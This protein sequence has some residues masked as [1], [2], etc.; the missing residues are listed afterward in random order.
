M[1]F[2]INPQVAYY[3]ETMVM[4]IHHSF[5][6]A[7]VRLNTIVCS[8]DIFTHQLMGSCKVSLFY[9]WKTDVDLLHLQCNPC[10]TCGQ[11]G[12]LEIGSQHCNK[13]TAMCGGVPITTRLSMGLEQSENVGSFHRIL[14][15]A[16][17]S[18][19]LWWKDCFKMGPLPTDKA[20]AFWALLKYLLLLK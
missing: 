14:A 6:K 8:H 20:D 3:F 10:W 18:I 17:P 12:I 19:F 13:M 4:G 7:V 11:F 16:K 15:G 2:K 9:L 1:Y 5:S